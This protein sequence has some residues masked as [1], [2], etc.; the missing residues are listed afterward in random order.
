MVA[1]DSPK[2]NIKKRR[3]L[4]V[5]DYLVYEIMDGQPYYYK[6]YRNVLNKTKTFEEIKGCSSYQW[7]IIEHLLR[8]ILGCAQTLNYR[9][10][11]NEPGLHRNRRNNL[12]GDILVYKKEDLPGSPIS[13]KYVAI[14]ALIHIE[15]DVTADTEGENEIY[16]LEK[17]VNKLLDFGTGKI[18]WIF[19]RS[20][21]ILIAT[22]K[23]N[24]QW[25][26]WSE[27]LHL[28]DE[29]NFNIADFLTQEGIDVNQES[30]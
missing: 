22:A 15:V 17:K 14:P 20:K 25:H 9:V 13:T 27:T 28:L 29:V 23:T 3:R 2:E 21:K 4:K 5:P 11:T 26:N 16:Y 12:A 1:L 18:I 19:T 6:G 8:L 30:E 24:W 10:A 7:I